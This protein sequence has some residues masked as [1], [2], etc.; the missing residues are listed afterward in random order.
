MMNAM[1]TQ[2]TLDIRRL[3]NFDGKP[4][5]QRA[6]YGIF[7]RQINTDAEADANCRLFAA[8]PDLLAACK[9]LADCLQDH[10]NTEARRVHVDPKILCPCATIELPRALAAIAKALGQ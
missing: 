2:G 10:I 8:A 7:N 6:S 3:P 1:Y 4:G 9:S 5:Q